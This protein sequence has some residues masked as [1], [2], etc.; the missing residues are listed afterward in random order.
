MRNNERRSSADSDIP[1]SGIRRK[2][3]RPE[4]S[5]TR[6]SLEV[7]AK[8]HPEFDKYDKLA[9]GVDEVPQEDAMHAEHRGTDTID[10]L[11]SDARLYW[12]RRSIGE[13]SSATMFGRHREKPLELA[14][15]YSTGVHEA[16]ERMS[17]AK[18]EVETWVAQMVKR[19][20]ATWQIAVQREIAKL[21]EERGAA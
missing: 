3:S 5:R 19:N 16:E 10:G 9:G 1:P 13:D 18:T 14:K 12:L 11:Y 15:K 8:E 6:K 20:S 7:R 21:E 4:A 17:D 2:V